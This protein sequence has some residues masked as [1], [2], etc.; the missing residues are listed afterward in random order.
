MV[1]SKTCFQL[2]GSPMEV[3]ESG[4]ETE[5]KALHAQLAKAPFLIGRVAG[6]LSH[7]ANEK[8]D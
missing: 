6:T 8:V 2:K 7:V 3:T 4:M 5:A 1:W